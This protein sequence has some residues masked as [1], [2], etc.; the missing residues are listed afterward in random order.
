MK[1]VF[2][3]IVCLL[4]TSLY[5]QEDLEL[6][7]EKA[8]SMGFTIENPSAY[9]SAISF[10]KVIN[11]K[12]QYLANDLYNKVEAYFTYTYNGGDNVIEVKNP[13]E[14]YVIAKGYYPNFY[15]ESNW[16]YS[17]VYAAEHIIRIDCKDNKVRVI[18]TI[19]N[20]IE[21]FKDGDIG[22][23]TARDKKP[24]L[25]IGYPINPGDT[26]KKPQKKGTDKT[27]YECFKGVVLA[28]E[29]HFEQ[30]EE[31]INKGNSILE[32]QDW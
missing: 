19:P 30:I 4:C 3:V 10:A 27:N 25:T 32:N 7:R 31:V 16:G 13:S 18:I 15:S 12:E 11:S 29:N 24:I 1:N 8:K 5:A 21:Q 20:Y 28:V 14:K 23:I 9:T 2:I 22:K 6:I 17:L 26:P